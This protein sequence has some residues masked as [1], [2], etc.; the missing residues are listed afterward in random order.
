[1]DLG[2]DDV[3]VPA[4]PKVDDED[5]KKKEL[6]ATACDEGTTLKNPMNRFGDAVDDATGGH[7]EMAN[8]E[9]TTIRHLE[10]VTLELSDKSTKPIW[11]Q[12]AK[13]GVFKG[14]SAGPF[15]MNAKTFAEIVAN[16][17]AQKN[18]LIPV[19][20]EHASEQHPAD[21]NIAVMGAPAQGWITQLV[22]RADGNLWGLVQWGDLA[23]KYIKSGSYKFLSP[24]VVFGSK[25]RVTGKPIGA[26]LSSVALTNNPFLDGMQPVAAKNTSSPVEPESAVVEAIRCALE[27]PAYMGPEHILAQLKIMANSSLLQGS[28]NKIREAL[29]LPLTMSIGDVFNEARVACGEI[30]APK[31]EV[32]SLAEPANHVTQT[33]V[34]AQETPMTVEAKDKGL[35]TQVSELTLKLSA[36]EAESK[37][38]RDDH[39]A[40]VKRLSDEN[41]D[42][43]GKLAIHMDKELN[44]VV[45]V[46]MSTYGEKMGLTDDKRT[47]LLHIAKNSRETFNALYPAVPANQRHLGTT[48]A[49][50]K[51]NVPTPEVNNVVNLKDIAAD[52]PTID[53]MVSKL[54]TDAKARGEKLSREEAYVLAHGER[55]KLVASLAK[56]HLAGNGG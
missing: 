1:M 13:Q 16:F 43:T 14:H 23:K 51:H 20:F 36:S 4:T 19:D 49:S 27:L 24:A 40:E 33:P 21:G 39:A 6:E 52:V 45:D 22:I 8:G 38:Q 11:I 9:E 37:R 28:G 32:L 26:R 30:F 34:S 12:I 29:R 42:L 47:H 41:A 48:I 46:A 35:E 10:E 54:M 15:E 53:T 2:P 5:E 17:T 56:K 3:H 18:Q 55:T 44:D 31:Q 7:H 25:D 50:G